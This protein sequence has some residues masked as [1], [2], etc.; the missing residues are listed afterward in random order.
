MSLI[1]GQMVFHL[2]PI[3]LYSM[4][5]FLKLFISLVL[6]SV[7]FACTKPETAD[8]DIQLSV[9]EKVDIP[10][11]SESMSFRVMFGKAPLATDKI[12]LGDPNGE[13][14][15]CEI[16]KTSSSSVTFALYKNM[17]SGVYNVYVQRGSFKKQIG[18][19]K[20]SITY[21][22]GVDDKD[23][24]LKAGNNVYGVVSCGANGV[25]GVVVSDGVEV[26]LTDKNGVYQFKSK[27]K[28]GHVFISVPSG[29]EAMTE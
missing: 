10:F 16:L 6:V 18:S 21:N 14:H 20:V 26:V 29:Y 4:K 17:V 5:N 1:S 24:E 8:F 3:L 23:I 22:S 27:K 12:V 13:L 25:E 2:M 15:I 19:M 9:P 7:P 11:G 28:L